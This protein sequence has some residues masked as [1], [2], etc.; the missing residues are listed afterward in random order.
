MLLIALGAVV[1]DIVTDDT[2]V[3]YADA[4]VFDIVTVCCRHEL[5][6]LQ[7]GFCLRGGSL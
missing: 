7:Q 6:C 4:D 2:N 1:M 3:M 5:C